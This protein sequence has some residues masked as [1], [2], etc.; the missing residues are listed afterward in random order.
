MMQ[1]LQDS[2]RNILMSVTIYDPFASNVGID[3]N[4]NRLHY[5]WIFIVPLSSFLQVESPLSN[6]K[7][8]QFAY[9]DCIHIVIQQARTAERAVLPTTVPSWPLTLRLNPNTT[10]VSWKSSVLPTGIP[11]SEIHI[12]PLTATNSVWIHFTSTVA[13]HQDPNSILCS[14]SERCIN[15]PTILCFAVTAQMLE[16]EV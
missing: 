3:E 11:H 15:T 4:W 16:L 7:F 5:P 8:S 6:L 13:T 2:M 1:C 14:E 10:E 12:Y 9:R